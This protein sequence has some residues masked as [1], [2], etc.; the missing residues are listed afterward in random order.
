MRK[1]PS[2]QQ[3]EIKNR[4]ARFDYFINEKKDE[5]KIGFRFIFQSKKTTLSSAEIE[6]VYNDIARECLK[7]EGI[8]IP[9]LN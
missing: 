2:A 8:T 9:G 6:L 4:R 1:K 3:A 5:I 7:I